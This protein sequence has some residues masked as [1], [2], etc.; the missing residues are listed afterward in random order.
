MKFYQYK[1]FIIDRLKTVNT[2]NF[3]QQRR[4][5]WH[6]PKILLYFFCVCLAVCT[7]VYTWTTRFQSVARKIVTFSLSSCFSEKNLF[8]LQAEGSSSN[9]PSC[10][11]ALYF[12]C[13]D[14]HQL[15]VN[16]RMK[17]EDMLTQKWEDEKMGVYC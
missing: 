3:I 14:K 12:I 17:N 15:L 8:F 13:S 9:L 6:S 4:G 10:I 11:S 1:D 7:L 16:E 5:K 2:E